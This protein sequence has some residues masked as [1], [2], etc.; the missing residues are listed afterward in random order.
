M[1][2]VP[3]AVKKTEM[4]SPKKETQGSQ[5]PPPPTLPRGVTDQQSGKG[6]ALDRTKGLRRVVMGMPG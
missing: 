1:I 3:V 2:L 6:D 5:T 4:D